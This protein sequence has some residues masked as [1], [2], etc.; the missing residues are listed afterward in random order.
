MKNIL[1]NGIIGCIL[2]CLLLSFVPGASAINSSYVVHGQL[3]AHG[4]GNPNGV[5]ITVTDTNNGESL[6]VNTYSDSLGNDGTY[7]VDLGNMPTQWKRND[8]ITLSA[9]SGGYSGT[10]S[11]DIPELGTIHAQDLNLTVHQGGGGGGRTERG[12][13]GGFSEATSYI[14]FG[15]IIVLV[16]VVLL[17]ALMSRKK[18][19]D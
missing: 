7:Q 17:F 18:R 15:I 2:L 1:K 10:A 9:N 3:N 4:G 11:F 14:F 16:I 5:T 12:G 13:G 6:T 19:G 8:T